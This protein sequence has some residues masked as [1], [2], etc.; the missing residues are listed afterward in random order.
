MIC[1]PLLFV[2]NTTQ[3]LQCVCSWIP[4]QKN[5][6][7]LI[8]PWMTLKILLNPWLAHTL[9]SI[10]PN[11]STEFWSFSSD[12]LTQLLKEKK[13][14]SHHTLPP[15]TQFTAQYDLC[16]SHC[17]HT[18]PQIPC[19]WFLQDESGTLYCNATYLK[20]NLDL[21][22]FTFTS[23]LS[24]TMNSTNTDSRLSYHTAAAGCLI[25]KVCRQQRESITA[26]KVC[27]DLTGS[28]LTM[29]KIAGGQHCQ[30]DRGCLK[31]RTTTKSVVTFIS[32]WLRK[33]G[34]RRV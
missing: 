27:S 26:S 3:T 31:S 19:E 16:F 12:P 24:S 9:G 1:L 23:L 28:L 15:K 14:K 22:N 5:R 29:V 21:S 11:K 6:V 17:S 20:W 30:S 4:A 25:N 8:W 33:P 34:C 7:L 10:S 18:M 13:K 2:N 32:C